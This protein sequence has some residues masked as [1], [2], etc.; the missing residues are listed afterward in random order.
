VQS[1][2]K[3]LVQGQCLIGQPGEKEGAE[4]FRFRVHLLRTLPRNGDTSQLLELDLSQCELSH[5]DL[6]QFASLEKLSMA[7]NQLKS[8]K[9]TDSFTGEHIS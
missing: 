2:T 6:G 4:N 9:S 7:N 5:V 1:T 8:L 3:H